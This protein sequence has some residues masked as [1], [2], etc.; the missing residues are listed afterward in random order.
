MKNI[1]ITG[2]GKRI[3]RALALKFAE[4]GWN[5][6]I[7]YNSSKD[8]AEKTLEEVRK[9]DVKTSIVKADV[10]NYNELKLAFEKSA[11]EIGLPDV[12][13]N[14]SGIFPSNRKIENIDD[15]FWDDVI[16]TNLRGEFF[17]SKIF[18]EITKEKSRIIN[19]ASLGAFEIWKEKTPYNVSKAGVIQ[20]TKALARELAPRI[21]VNSV[22][23]G[24]IVMPGEPG[25][26]PN[27]INL[28]KIPMGRYGNTDDVFDAVYFFATCSDFITGQNISV[29]GGYHL[30]K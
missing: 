22:S 23:P 8:A 7:H 4:K 19:F 16:N 3:G 28:N 9:Y 20:L 10:K 14:N 13:V 11:D 29:D 5:V 18:S 6:T 12:L 15:V 25:P 30:F 24:T 21:S 2:S 17:A 1:I 27:N 26:D